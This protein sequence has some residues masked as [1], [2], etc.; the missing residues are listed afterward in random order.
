M[1]LDTSRD[2]H[3]Y[4]DGVD[5]PIDGEFYT[6]KGNS[7]MFPGQFGVAEED[8]NCLCWVTYSK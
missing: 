6:F 8:C 7:A 5:A 1:M 4:L 2:T 3:I